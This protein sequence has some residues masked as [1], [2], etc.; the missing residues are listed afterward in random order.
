MPHFDDLAISHAVQEH[1][2][3]AHLSARWRIPPELALVRARNGQIGRDEVT[4]GDEIMDC[5]FP[6]RKATTLPFQDLKGIMHSDSTFRAPTMEKDIWG[7]EL[8]EGV[9]VASVD[10]LV[11]A[12][13]YSLVVFQRHG[14]LQRRSY[15]PFD[16]PH[17]VRSR[18]PLQ[19]HLLRSAE[20]ELSAALD[21][22]L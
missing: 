11:I 4:L 6:V 10:F 14:A 3:E 19:L 5:N 1:S 7:D 8:F 15:Y 9:Q 13:D 17:L 12:S 2:G 16:R 20:L 18:Q 21:Q 22:R